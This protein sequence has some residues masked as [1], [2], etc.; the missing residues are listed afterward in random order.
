[1]FVAAV[2]INR[3]ESADFPNDICSV[4]NQEG[5]FN[6]SSINKA[7]EA[8]TTAELVLSGELVVPETDALYFH[9][10]EKPSYLGG[11]KFLF[12]YGG[13]DFYE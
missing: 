10:G 3:V 4:V 11:K 9:S 5:Q 7:E 2:V 8:Y 6:N 12:Q 1:M 13:H